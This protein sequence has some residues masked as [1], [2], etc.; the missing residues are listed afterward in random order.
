MKRKVIQLAGK[1]SVISLPS[2]WVQQQ[3]IKKGDELE[4]KEEGSKIIVSSEKGSIL[5]N[6]Q[7]DLSD[8]D[9]RE[10]RGFGRPRGVPTAQH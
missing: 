6:I 2:K 1:T 8:L 4:I 10:R 5:Q 9:R 3:G 7:V